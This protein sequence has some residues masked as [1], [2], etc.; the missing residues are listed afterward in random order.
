MLEILTGAGLAIAA[1]MN[2]YVPLL[3][4]GVADRFIG[5]VDLPAAWQWL[6]NEWVLGVLGLLLVV[7]I[8]ADKIPLVDSVN[9]WLQTIIRPTSGGIVFGSGVASETVAVTDPAEFF[10]SDRWV[11]IAIGAGLALT[12]HV[13]KALA[14]PALNTLTAGAAAPV[15]ST[16]EDIGSVLLTLAAIVLPILVIAGVVF[17]VVAGLFVVRRVRRTRRPTPV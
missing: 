13:V 15:M 9:D 6:S 1:G 7:E 17:V 3:A 8:V 11:P 16:L 4:L 14:R 2:A 10:S 5:A 12:V